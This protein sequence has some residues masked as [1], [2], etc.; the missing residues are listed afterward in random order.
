MLSNFVFSFCWIFVGGVGAIDTWLAVHLRDGLKDNERNPIARLILESNNWEVSHFI[1][2]KMF[3]TI[4]VLGIVACLFKRDAKYGLV[5]IGA[6]SIIQA[7]LLYCL[8]L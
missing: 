4:L 7:I 6:L 1:G 8:S 2:L 3:G 5:I